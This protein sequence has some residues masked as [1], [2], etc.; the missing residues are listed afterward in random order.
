MSYEMTVGENDVANRRILRLALGVTLALTFSQ[1]VNWPLSYITGILTLILLGLPAPAPT[2]KKGI[3]FVIVLILP[4]GV[5]TLIFIPL[6][7]YARWSG[8]LLLI[9]ALFGCFYFSA[10]GGS[11]VLGLFL[12]ISL[13]L[14]AAIGSVSIDALLIVI[15]SMALCA[16]TSMF[17][18]W[19]AHA[20]LPELPLEIKSKPEAP[21][22]SLRHA[23]HHALRSLVI[24]LPVTI[25]ILFSGSSAAYLPLMLKVVAMGQQANRTM[26]HQVGLEQIEST[27][28]G[29]FAA[30]IAWQVMSIWPSLIMFGLIMALSGLFFASRIF[31]G[32]GMHPKTDMWSYAFLTMIIILTPALADSQA[33]NGADTA[34]YSR[35]ALFIVIGLYGWLSVAVFDEFFPFKEKSLPSS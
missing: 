32:Y 16:T 35:L 1:T 23:R 24:I 3:G 12:T 21:P 6:F 33:S 25:L 2:L 5:G 8:I 31:K 22:P 11:M 29:G 30:I 9:L 4:L 13:A 19:L 10:R 27:L 28:W 20:F 34:F 18:V 7:E 15:S 14:I 26:S 17:F